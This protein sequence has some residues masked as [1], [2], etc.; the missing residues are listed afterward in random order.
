MGQWNH[1]LASQTMI[2]QLGSKSFKFVPSIYKSGSV[3]VE[4]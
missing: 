4:I 3:S 1:G 2:Y